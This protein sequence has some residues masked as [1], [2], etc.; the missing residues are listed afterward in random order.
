[1][2][3]FIS[4]FFKSVLYLGIAGLVGYSE[5]QTSGIIGVATNLAF[6]I[7]GG[8]LVATWLSPKR[9]ESEQILEAMSLNAHNI[10]A[11][12][13]GEMGGTARVETITN[14]STQN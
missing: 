8:F 6:A 4:N 12:V 7:L 5:Y 3:R 11:N 1:M 10:N 2:K 9:N 14:N 13:A